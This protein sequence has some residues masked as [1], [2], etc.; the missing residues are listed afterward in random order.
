MPIHHGPSR[1]LYSTPQT[2]SLRSSTNFI[3]S[4]SGVNRV[5]P[6]GT[7]VSS[8]AESDTGIEE[9]E[10]EEPPPTIVNTNHSPRRLVALISCYQC[11]MAGLPCSRTYPAC[12][13]CERAGN[14]DTCL[15][16]RRKLPEEITRKTGFNITPTL[17]MVEGEDES[18]RQ[19]KVARLEEVQSFFNCSRLA[20]IY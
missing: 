2:I 3:P 9:P 1:R 7:E 15:L 12:S 17:L 5:P 16:F 18:V 13:R 11:V 10:H 6:P 14:A 4:P 8:V 20:F 19:K